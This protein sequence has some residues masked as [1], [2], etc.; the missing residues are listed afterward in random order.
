MLVPYLRSISNN[1]QMK[2]FFLGL[3][4]FVAT[5]TLYAQDNYNND[6]NTEGNQGF[7]KENVFVGGSVSL[8]FG[9]GSFGVGANPEIGYSVAQWL[10]AGVALNINYNSQ[11]LYDASG[12]G[13][14][15]VGRIS[16]FN[17]GGGVFARLYPVNFLFAQLQP[18]VNW[19]KYYQKDYTTGIK[20]NNTVSAPSLIAGI[21]YSQRVI[22]QGSYFFMIGFDVLHDKNS[23]YQDG[24]GH[25]QPIIRGGFDIYLHPSKKVMPEGR[26]L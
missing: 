10:D 23:P 9:S 5:K 25:S 8:G 14:N 20:A 13:Y 22:T 4:L 12:Y 21:G 11:K 17:Y 7:K 1:K 24:Y 2:K 6:N 16:S 26:T 15:Y 19:I 3:L 18:E